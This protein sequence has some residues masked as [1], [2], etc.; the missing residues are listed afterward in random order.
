[1]IEVRLPEILDEVI[2]L[3]RL[4]AR[5]SSLELTVTCE[6]DE[7]DRLV[8]TDPL[9]VR[10]ILANLIGNAIKFTKRGSVTV[11]LRAHVEENALVAEIEVRDTESAFLQSKFKRSFKVMSKV[12]P[13]LHV[14]LEERGWVWQ[15]RRGLHD[16]SMDRSLFARRSTREVHLHLLSGASCNEFC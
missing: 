4:R 14:D 12:I 5:D 15:F 3:L 11:L 8:R 13:V 7:T 16:C 10:Q 6:G 1:M 9:R 2:Q